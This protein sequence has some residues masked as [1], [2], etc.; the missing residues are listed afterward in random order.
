MKDMNSF[1]NVVH[2]LKT[3]FNVD[4]GLSEDAAIK[5]Y[6]RTAKSSGKL[7]NL[8]EELV[9]G[10]SDPG[11]SWRTLLSNEGYEVFDA[12]TEEDARSY[13]VRVLWEPLQGL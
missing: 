1:E 5:I 9:R 2:M 12:E 3:V 11:V 6:R 10:L 13:A 8:R 4:T 7:E